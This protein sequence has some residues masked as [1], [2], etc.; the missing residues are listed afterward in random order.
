[1]E[2]AECFGLSQLH[3]L[4]GRIGRGEHKSTCIL[5]SDTAE[6]NERLKAICSTNDGFKIAEE[7]LKLRGPGDFI[8]HRQHGLPEMKIADICADYTLMKSTQIQ[9]REL[10]AK[11][12]DLSAS[13]NEP[14]K[15]AVEEM[16]R[17]I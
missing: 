14:L 3:Q 6:H 10:L 16:L 1:M 9:A 4:R 11:D 12:S 15:R 2:N 13:Q 8:G 5:I 17:R 7:D